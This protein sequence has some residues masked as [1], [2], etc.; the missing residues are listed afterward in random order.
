MS[1][2]D[3]GFLLS[4]HMHRHPVHAQP[5][6]CAL[7]QTQCAHEISARA[8]RHEWHTGLP[9]LQL[10]FAPHVSRPPVR[11]PLPATVSE[12][13]CRVKFSKRRKV[14]TFVCTR[15]LPPGDSNSACR[16]VHSAVPAVTVVRQACESE[17]PT[18]QAAARAELYG[19]CDLP[20]L[21]SHSVQ[22]TVEGPL[23]SVDP[24]V[25]WQ[26]NV[27]AEYDQPTVA[28]EVQPELVDESDEHASHHSPDSLGECP[29]RS[30]SPPPEDTCAVLQELHLQPSNNTLAGRPGVCMSESEEPVRFRCR[31]LVCCACDSE[32]WRVRHQRLLACR[33]TRALSPASRVLSG[34]TVI[35]QP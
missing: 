27:S 1:Q 29:A 8:A 23:P 22:Q 24:T 6:V 30:E 19:L 12:T 26:A 4:P 11:V 3:H 15:L 33:E 5:L 17:S 28:S 14:L 25:P 9:S 20:A 21:P 18:W 10:V 35:C 34:F 16:D 2:P 7:Q 31:E 32:P 13:A